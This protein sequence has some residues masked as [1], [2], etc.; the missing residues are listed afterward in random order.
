MHNLHWLVFNEFLN[1]NRLKCLILDRAIM[2][3]VVDLCN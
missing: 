1:I 2:L 3:R